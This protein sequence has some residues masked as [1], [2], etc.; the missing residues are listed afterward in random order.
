[1]AKINKYKNKITW[2]E[3]ILLRQNG[4]C[5]FSSMISY[6]YY[7]D[8]IGIF[9]NNIMSKYYKLF[10]NICKEWSLKLA[11]YRNTDGSFNNLGSNAYFWSASENSSTNAWNRNLNS[12]NSQSGRGNFTKG[13]GFAVRCLR[14]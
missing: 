5:L 14:D 4:V 2:R 6:T 13:D 11:G 7:D 9:I 3:S 8:S 1:M 10:Y 12:G